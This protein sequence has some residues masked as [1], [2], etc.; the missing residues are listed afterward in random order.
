MS[1]NAVTKLKSQG[2]DAAQD[3][4]PKVSVFDIIIPREGPLAHPRADD[5]VDEELLTNAN[6][7]GIMD[8]GRVSRPVLV[9]RNGVVDGKLQLVLIAGSRRTNGL[10][11]AVRRWKENGTFREGMHRI[12]VRYF[13]G[14]EKAAWKARLLENSDPEKKADSAKVLAMSA[15]AMR[16]VQMTDEEILAVMPRSVRTKADLEALLR[17][18]DLTPEAASAFD[19]GAPLALLGKVLDAPRDKQAE[20]V[21]T[22]VAAGATTPQKA[23]RIVNRA[24]RENGTKAPRPFTPKQIRALTVGANKL[25]VTEEMEMLAH[26]PG[27]SEYRENYERAREFDAFALFGKLI[28]GEIKIDDLPPHLYDM[29]QEVLNKK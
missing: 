16:K 26:N 2:I 1:M 11:E 20:T 8:L 4:Q 19:S 12:D 29:V 23:A 5:P 28:T 14:D 24:A 9:W 15:I 18:G 27:T 13:V 6:G 21:Q 17:W 7:T 25:G 3:A 22:L 10:I